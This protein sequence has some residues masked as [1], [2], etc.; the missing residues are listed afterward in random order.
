M[1]DRRV[2]R[3]R[4][5]KANFC[6][7]IFNR[8]RAHDASV[9]VVDCANQMKIFDENAVYE[10]IYSNYHQVILGFENGDTYQPKGQEKFLAENS[11]IWC[12]PLLT[13]NLNN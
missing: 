4:D 13:P 3:K 11:E 2:L 7:S 6:I 8:P 5:M 9:E 12:M 1:K 10:I